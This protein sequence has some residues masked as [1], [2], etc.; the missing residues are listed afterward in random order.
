MSARIRPVEV[1]DL[2][3]LTRIYNHYIE[4]TAITFDVATFTPEERR[5]WLSGFLGDG[6]YRC[7]VAELDDEPVGWACSG[8][9]RE[10]AAYESSLETSIYLDPTATGRGLGTRLYRTLLEDL[11][12]SDFHLA[13]GGV[14]LPNS[15]SVALHQHF[16]FESVGIFREVGRKFDRY[17]DVQWFQKRLRN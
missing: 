14:T 3:E 6:P 2:A 4:H 13:V 15:A 8:R 11:V 7:F 1:R 9:F 10:K 16:G 17:W 12:D 5:P